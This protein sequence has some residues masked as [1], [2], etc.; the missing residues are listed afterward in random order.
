MRRPERARRAVKE[1]EGD[2]SRFRSHDQYRQRAPPFPGAPRLMPQGSSSMSL[3]SH[4]SEFSPQ[5]VTGKAL[6][7]GAWQ[8]YRRIIGEFWPIVEHL[9]GPCLWLR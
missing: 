1:Q 2:V 6:L 9:R 7:A 4:W 5:I 3:A 8:Q